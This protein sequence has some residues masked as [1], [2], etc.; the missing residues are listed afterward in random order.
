MSETVLIAILSALAGAIGG[1][2]LWLRAH[3]AAC[4]ARW[5]KLLEEHGAIKAQLATLTRVER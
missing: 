5:E 2:A 3:D 4:R 1:L